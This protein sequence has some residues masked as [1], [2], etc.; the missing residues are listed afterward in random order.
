MIRR[1]TTDNPQDNLEN[2][3]NLFFVKNKETW[4][5]N[6]GPAPDYGDISL[7]NLVR[8]IAREHDLE[9]AQSEDDDEISCEMADILHG[10]EDL[11]GE[12]VVALLYTAGWVCAELRAKLMDYEDTGFTPNEVA[13]MKPRQ[14]NW[15]GEGDGYADGAMVYD[16]WKCDQCG[17]IIDD[18]TDDPEQLPKFCPNCGA[19]M[20]GELK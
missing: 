6:Y 19:N 3:L 13:E 14:G 11:D 16:V 17:Y 5:R 2:A 4:V 15:N 10:E 8:E 9:I 18:G 20:K 7:N 12:A 1:L